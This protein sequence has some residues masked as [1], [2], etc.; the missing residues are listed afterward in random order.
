MLLQKTDVVLLHKAYQ[1]W[2]NRSEIVKENKWLVLKSSTES[3][4]STLRWTLP[5]P[6]AASYLAKQKVINH[7]PFTKCGYLE[8]PVMTLENKITRKERVVDKKLY[9]LKHS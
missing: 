5:Y 6:H 7:P 3:S 4:Q 1:K 8:N 2:L 9:T